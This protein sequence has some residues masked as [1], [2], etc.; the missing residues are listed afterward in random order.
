[1]Y[2]P[3]SPCVICFKG[4]LFPSAQWAQTSGMGPEGPIGPELG[5][6][7]R[8][9]WLPLVADLGLIMPISEDRVGFHMKTAWL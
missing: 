1:M 9:G 7:G 4:Q 6:P 2:L 5:D 8:T 3:L